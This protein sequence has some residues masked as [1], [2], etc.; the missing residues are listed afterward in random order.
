MAKTT[1]L[2]QL[3]VISGLTLQL[4]NC[5]NCFSRSVQSAKYP[6]QYNNVL[7]GK[8]V[9]WFCSL[10]P[11]SPPKKKS[12]LLKGQPLNWYRTP[13]SN[14]TANLCSM[15]TFGSSQGLVQCNKSSWKFQQT[16]LLHDVRYKACCG[17][18]AQWNLLHKNEILLK[19]KGLKHP[20]F[21]LPCHFVL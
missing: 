5:V 14:S 15:L 12:V 9:C 13:T 2:E 4:Q 8:K 6:E 16:T 20:L 17:F 19:T 10:P 11:P 7:L 1:T 18:E 21:T 3:Q